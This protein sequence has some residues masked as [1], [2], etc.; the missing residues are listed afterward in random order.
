M[1]AFCN[2]SVLNWGTLEIKDLVIG[3]KTVDGVESLQLRRLFGL[4]KDGPTRGQGD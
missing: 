2:G 3:P 1:G 4:T